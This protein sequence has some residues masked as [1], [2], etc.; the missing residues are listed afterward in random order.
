MDSVTGRHVLTDAEET[1]L[2]KL[3]ENRATDPRL[4]SYIVSYIEKISGKKWVEESVLEKIRT[5]ITAQKDCYWKEGGRRI[6]Q[7]KGGYSVLAYMAYQMPG[8]AAELTEFFSRL[9]RDGLMRDHIRI[10]DVGAGPGTVAVAVARVLE[11]C[12]AATAEIVALE[13]AEIF[14]EAYQAIVPAFVKEAGDRVTAPRPIA[15]DV[16]K[17]IPDGEFDLIICSNVINELVGGDDLRAEILMRLS[18]HLVQDGTLILIEPADLANATMLRN[19]SRDLK[20]RGLTL[21]APCNDIRGVHCQVSPCWT[22]ATYADI[23]P[24][25]LMLALGEGKEKYRFVNTDVKFSYAVLR[26]DGHRRCSYRVPA[27]AKRARL[28]QL[29]KHVGRRIHVTVSVISADIGDAKNYLYLICDG[30]GG[31]PAYVALP[32][33]HRNSGHEALLSVQYGAVV[34]I[35]SVLVRFNKN[36]N[37]YNLL[38]GPKSSTRMIVGVPGFSVPD[39]IVMLKE[40]YGRGSG[41]KP[42]GTY[43]Q[44]PQ[45][46]K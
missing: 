24:T 39:K 29:K 15:A 20:R 5:E 43:C 37:A 38:M 31:I 40:K 26:R 30:T 14:R 16:T 21:Y 44:R 36:Q 12:D 9:I 35:D 8:Y 10:L 19:L 3:I 4:D 1:R 13:R 18:G 22:F 46:K 17:S 2:Q 33:H 23:K 41:K 42:A 34:A 32:A 11:Q 45:N 6:V 7:Y 25:K 27:A 28:S